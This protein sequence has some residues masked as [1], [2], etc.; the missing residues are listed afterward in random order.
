MSGG[1]IQNF[2]MYRDTHKVFQLTT[3]TFERKGGQ[4]ERTFQN[5]C[6][7]NDYAVKLNEIKKVK[8]REGKTAKS[9]KNQTK[10]RRQ[11]QQ[12]QREK[13]CN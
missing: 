3:R 9:T 1:Q 12:Q 8:A 10:K 2:N 11:Q 6:R 5:N 4:G 13:N 7:N